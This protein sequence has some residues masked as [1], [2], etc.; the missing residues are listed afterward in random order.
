L[1]VA[2]NDRTTDSITTVAK[3]LDKRGIPH[4]MVDLSAVHG[5]VAAV[6]RD[7]GL[8]PHGVR[9]T[10]HE[11]VVGGRARVSSGVI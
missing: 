9:R 11:R 8:R 6:V 4:R 7:G 1:Q 10:R 2:E 3:I 5:H